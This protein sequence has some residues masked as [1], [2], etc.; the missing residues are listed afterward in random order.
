MK[1][2]STKTIPSKN[3]LTKAVVTLSEKDTLPL[4]PKWNKTQLAVAVL[5]WIEVA[6]D[7]DDNNMQAETHLVVSFQKDFPS[8]MEYKSK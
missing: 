7:F 2:P 8:V 6:S 4:S 3:L 5:H 1:S